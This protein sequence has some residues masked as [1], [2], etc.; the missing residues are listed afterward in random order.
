MIFIAFLIAVQ[1]S[2]SDVHIH[3]YKKKNQIS[4]KHHIQTISYRN[5]VVFIIL[6]NYSGCGH[7]YS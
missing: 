5:R 1:I 3:Y 7:V 6:Y 2:I 4:R